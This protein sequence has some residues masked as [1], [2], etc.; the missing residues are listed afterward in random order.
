[1]ARSAHPCNGPSRG[2][3]AAAIG[4]LALLCHVHLPPEALAETSKRSGLLI[5]MLPPAPAWSTI[6]TDSTAPGWR[7][8]AASRDSKPKWVLRDVSSIAPA[9]A[10]SPR[11]LSTEPTQSIPYENPVFFAIGG[12]IR[13]SKVAGV[14]SGE[15][16]SG[17]LT[18]RLAYKLDQDFSLSLRPSYIFGNRDLQGN[19]NNEGE[20][21]MPLTIDLF[22]KALIS[23]YLGGGIVT[24]TDSTGAT[25]PMLTA[26]V[27]INITRNLVLGL[28]VNYIF[29]ND[30]GDTDKQGMSLLYLRF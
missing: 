5:E 17:V 3:K 22:H 2:A 19:N 24:N 15:A 11:E 30:I 12:G 10:P 7:T 27:D 9:L 29:Q 20:F 28:N 16:F 13:L 26:G 14:D 18:G 21:Q 8:T 1:M 25:N 4:G 6:P 23:P